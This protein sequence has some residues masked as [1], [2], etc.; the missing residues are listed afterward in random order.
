MADGGARRERTYPGVDRVDLAIRAGRLA[1]YLW[2]AVGRL[3][4][5]LYQLDAWCS[6]E[7]EWP[8]YF[9]TANLRLSTYG[10]AEPLSPEAK[11]RMLARA[12]K[13]QL[14]LFP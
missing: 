6:S 11:E 10:L 5:F 14:E 2:E 12:M 8:W 7:E 1:D 13:A 3:S 4:H 9:A